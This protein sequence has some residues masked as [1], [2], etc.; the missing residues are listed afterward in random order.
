MPGSLRF[1]AKIAVASILVAFILSLLVVYFSNFDG[2]ND[3]SA[4]K[5]K[6]QEI[7]NR[8]G[9]SSKEKFR[10]CSYP[11]FDFGNR[12]IV[13]GEGLNPKDASLKLSFKK[14]KE[15]F[16]LGIHFNLSI[17]F[18][19]SVEVGN[20]EFWVKG[21][22]NSSKIKSI[23]VCLREGLIIARLVTSSIPADIKGEWIK[24]SVPLSSFQIKETAAS[25][26]SQKVGFTWSIEE[27]I[28]SLSPFEENENSE[29][30]INRIK[31]IDRGKNKVIY[32]L[33]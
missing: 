32:D 19:P 30:I 21:I 14:Y 5:D 18:G 26:Q 2:K 6:Q 31:I 12:I 28:F 9:L 29:I 17:D 11:D 1:L 20:L 33:F 3:L 8:C 7:E 13:A 22:K 23:D 27:V 24:L 4:L 16:F 25:Q 10:L 15:K